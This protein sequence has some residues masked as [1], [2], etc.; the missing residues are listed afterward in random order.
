MILVSNHNVFGTMEFIGTIHKLY[1][2]M[3]FI[4]TIH[5]DWLCLSL[6][7]IQDSV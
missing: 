6:K 1:G 5:K 7:K 3:E 2:T 4:E